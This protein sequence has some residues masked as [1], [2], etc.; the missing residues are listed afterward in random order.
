MYSITIQA[1]ELIGL[2]CFFGEFVV[3]P[4]E[5]LSELEDSEIDEDD[6]DNVINV[7]V[8]LTGSGCLY[9]T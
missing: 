1:L 4:K 8:L 5:D 7:D 6:D 9:I 3:S 2:F